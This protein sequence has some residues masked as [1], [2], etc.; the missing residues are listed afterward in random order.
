MIQKVTW[1]I[2]Y[3]QRFIYVLPQMPVNTGWVLKTVTILT[4]TTKLE[5]APLLLNPTPYILDVIVGG[6]AFIPPLWRQVALCD[7][8][9]ETVTT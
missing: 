8:A 6:M 4:L 1:S 9:T 2:S 7:G 5:N 3:H